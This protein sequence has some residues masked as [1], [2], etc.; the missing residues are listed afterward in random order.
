DPTHDRQ[1]K[2]GSRWFGGIEGQ[3][4]LVPNERIHARPAVADS[5]EDLSRPTLSDERDR[6]RFRSP[7]RRCRFRPVAQKVRKN[8]A[9]KNGGSPNFGQLS[10]T[11]DRGLRKSHPCIGDGLFH[12]GSEVDG[13]RNEF[14]RPRKEKKIAGHATQLRGLFAD[15]LEVFLR[16]FRVA[17]RQVG[18]SSDRSRRIPELMRRARG[19]FTE[20]RQVPRESHARFQPTYFGEIR[21][22][23]Q[24]PEESAIRAARRSDGH[25]DDSLAIPL[26]PP[27]LF[28]GNRFPIVEGCG[29]QIAKLR[30]LL[31]KS[32]VPLSLPV[33]RR[34]DDLSSRLVELHDHALRVD[35]KQSRR[36]IASER[37]RRD[38]E[39]VRPF[40]LDSGEPGELALFFGERRDRGLEARDQEIPLILMRSGRG[41]HRSRLRG[42]EQTL[43]RG[44][45]RSQ[46]EPGE[47]D[48]DAARQGDQNRR[49][50]GIPAQ[51]GART[52][53]EG[54]D[55]NSLPTR[56]RRKKKIRLCS[57][58]RPR[59]A[60]GG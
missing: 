53:I 43:V 37:S 57:P 54:H 21:K 27:D 2:S 35:G 19:H 46:V 56:E 25:P 17:Q 10:R 47:N 36:K 6:I 11:G 34:P 60:R 48:E 7:R 1:S 5:K 45:E 44:E 39:I 55:E 3:K 33:L 51:G 20:I 42:L 28:S 13:L 16:A 41:S 12:D 52:G 31:E 8:A 29:D 50:A 24:R 49:N 40:L 30:S 38:L 32:L 14:L 18:K 26:A 59:T 23:S 22:Q 9:K 15:R 58:F 4:N